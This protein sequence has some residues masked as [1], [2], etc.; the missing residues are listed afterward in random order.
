M[1]NLKM[2]MD[3]EGLERVLYLGVWEGGRNWAD[4]V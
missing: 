4:V 2:L 1:G 3:M